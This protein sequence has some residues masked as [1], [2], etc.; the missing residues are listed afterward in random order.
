MRA[1]LRE[2]PEIRTVRAAVSDLNGQARGKRI[3]AR[4]GESS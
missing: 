1:W 3:P 2:H 4:F